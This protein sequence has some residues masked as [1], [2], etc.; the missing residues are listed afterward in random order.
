MEF[1]NAN[2]N[3]DN[4]VASNLNNANHFFLKIVKIELNKNIIH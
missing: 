3:G 2:T 1:E 4:I